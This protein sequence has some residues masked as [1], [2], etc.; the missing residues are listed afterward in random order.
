M[1]PAIQKWWSK[2]VIFKAAQWIYCITIINHNSRKTCSQ[3]WSSFKNK[4]DG[5]GVISR[6][7][8][9]GIYEWLEF[10]DKCK[11]SFFP[12]QENFV[13]FL[14]II[15]WK[16]SHIVTL[17]HIM[18]VV[19]A[20]CVQIQNTKKFKKKKKQDKTLVRKK[21]KFFTKRKGGLVVYRVHIR[22]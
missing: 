21:V 12:C 3:Y 16:S 9:D 2:W 6:S 19:K 1:K 15:I 8:F 22:E 4:F 10:M 18:Q 20:I 11:K 7:I 5:Y 14:F 17:L 13:H